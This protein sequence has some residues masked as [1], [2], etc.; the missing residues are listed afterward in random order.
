M[1]KT[2]LKH[3]QHQQRHLLPRR[4]AGRVGEAA[5]LLELV[6][7][8]AC[9]LDDG[10]PSESVAEAIDFPVQGEVTKHERMEQALLI[11]RAWTE[12]ALLAARKYRADWH[13][14]LEPA[15]WWEA[16][17]I[18]REEMEEFAVDFCARHARWPRA[19]DMRRRFG[20][21]PGHRLPGEHEGQEVLG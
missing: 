21:T 11:A 3:Y 17:E 16:G 5:H 14:L 8:A 9:L 19:D 18:E 7:I 2:N 4:E 13:A 6:D 15:R 10:F 20:K 12:G 1:T